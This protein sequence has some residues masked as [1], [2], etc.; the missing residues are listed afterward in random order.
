MVEVDPVVVVFRYPPAGRQCDD[1]LGR[2]RRRRRRLSGCRPLRQGD[3][4]DAD[5][6][7]ARVIVAGQAVGGSA[8]RDG[9]RGERDLT[10]VLT[11]KPGDMGEKYR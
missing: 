7:H 1:R 5:V 9:N 3:V 10:A 8:V 2:G 4:T 6:R 11:Q